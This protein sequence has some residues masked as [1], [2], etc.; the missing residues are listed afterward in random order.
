MEFGWTEEQQLLR[1]TARAF[2]D[3]HCPPERAKQWDEEAYFPTEMVAAM[4]EMGWFGLPFPAEWGGG[5][6]S[7]VEMTIIA[8]ELSRASFDIGMLYIG[9]FIPGLAVYHWA[10]ETMRERLQAGLLT[11]S[12]RFA[13]AMSEPDAGSD[14]ASMRTTA[15][16]DGDHF[17]VNGTKMWCTGGGLP[18]VLLAVYVRTNPSLPKHKGLSL[19]L[20]DPTSEGVEVRRIP[21]LARHVLGTNEI[22]FNDVRVPKDNLI[23]PLDGGWGVLMSNLELERTIISGA[24][25]GAAQSTLDIALEYSK[26]RQQFDRPVGTFQALAHQLA[27]LQVEVDS[28]RLLTYRAAWMLANGL[29]VDREG[30]MAKLKG[31]ETYVQ[32]ARWGMQIMAA[33]G[34]ATESV[35]S[36]RYRESIVAPISGGTS[37]IQ[38]N[39]IGRS[40]GL[41]SY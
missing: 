40:M 10:D 5:G 32:V 19:L 20:I 7:A 37:Q 31:S 28:S 3:R 36:F 26:Q 38:R 13:V 12:Q 23:G 8:E 6:G 27:D 14:L 34:F 35:M 9:T 22:H 24:Y 33:H 25:V 18:G 4:G 11:G 2:V 41:R 21:T 39:A 16:Q 29:P 1:E 17:V 30:A 15:V